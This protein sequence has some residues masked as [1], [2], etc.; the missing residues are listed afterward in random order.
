MPP[1]GGGAAPAG[2]PGL[3]DLLGILGGGRSQVTAGAA[4]AKAAQNIRSTRAHILD[5]LRRLGK[6]LGGS[7]GGD[8]FD[9]LAAGARDSASVA[10]AQETA[11][12]TGGPAVDPR[13]ALEGAKALAPAVLAAV[14]AGVILYMWRR[15]A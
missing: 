8:F 13:A 14:L 2:A 5:K 7:V 4:A 3:K 10:R 9:A 11:R 1:T 15:G 6:D 12:L